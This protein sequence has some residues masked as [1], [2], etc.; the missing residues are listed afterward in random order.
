MEVKQGSTLDLF[1]SA[2]SQS[3]ESTTESSS[4][5]PALAA[6]EDEDLSGEEQEVDPVDQRL[7]TEDGEV[8]DSSEDSEEDQPTSNK[9]IE[10][11]TVKDQHGQRRKVK[12]DYSDKD[13]IKRAFSLAAGARKWQ[14]ER[15]SLQ[16]ELNSFRESA[17][18]KIENW[19][20]IS[21]L[22]E[23]SG[24]K[25]LV[26][27][28][29]GSDDA[30]DKMIDQANQEREFFS[31]A[32]P[33]Q[34]EAYELKQTQ[35][36]KDRELEKL[37]KE[38]EDIKNAQAN[39]SE[40][41]ELASIKAEINPVFDKYRF[42]G[43]L[44][45]PQHENMLDEMLWNNAMKQLESYP[46]DMDITPQTINKVFKDY[47]LNLRTLVNKQAEKKVASTVAKKKRQ[48]TETAQIKAAKSMATNKSGETARDMIQQGRLGDLFKTL[49]T[50]NKN[51][52]S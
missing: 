22:Y 49:A 34:L 41:A 2:L 29:E 43:K 44:G 45:N 40:E 25:G 4:K 11:L 3:S 14:A 20:K 42:A 9:D 48:A 28:L 37:R 35:S 16:K 17:G 50:R 6:I 38:I 32:T 5:T 27:Y 39:S 47:A 21:S 1:N 18:T 36:Q 13:S 30:Y 31:S 7:S 15:D 24:I 23:D 10:Y 51:F 8:D 19:D 12:V 26:N 52:V 33:E 46:E